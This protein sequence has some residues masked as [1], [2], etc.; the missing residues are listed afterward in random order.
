MGARDTFL[1]G[2]AART[3]AL[4]ADAPALAEG[5]A[6]ARLDDLPSGKLEAFKYTPVEALYDQGLLDPAPCPAPGPAPF[7]LTDAI[8]LPASG[9][10]IAAAGPSNGISARALSDVA[11]ALAESNAHLDVGR[12]PLVHLNTSLLRDGLIVH[13]AARQRPVTPVVLDLA[14]MESAACTRVVLVLEAGSTLTLIEPHH[15]PMVANRVLDIRLGPGAQLHHT[16]WQGPTDRSAWQLTSA[17]L[18]ADADYRFETYCCAG[19]PHRNDVHVRLT[20]ARAKFELTGVQMARG[21]G[22]LDQ[23]V[24]VEHIG[25]D[26]RSRQTL[27]GLALERSRLSFNGR[28]HIHPGARGTD[29]RLTNRNLLLDD[30]AHVNTKPELEIYADDVQCGHGATVG[31]LD[32]A[33][34]FYLTSRGIDRQAARD[35]LMQA[36]LRDCLPEGSLGAELG[37]L[38]ARELEAANG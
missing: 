7:T 23:Q 16:R 12:Y 27:H 32:E 28:I 5:R 29:A 10:G 24:T 20:G 38:L 3:E 25:P 1:A 13:V 6:A 9:I 31:Q 22:R 21:T 11:D 4:A 2:L 17:I 18:D 19:A 8:A 34:L 14:S 26:G 30:R 15:Q 36:F 37:T 35:L 33:A